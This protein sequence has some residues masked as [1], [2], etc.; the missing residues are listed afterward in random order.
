MLLSLLLVAASN[1]DAACAAGR[2]IRWGIMGSGLIS[3]DFVGALKALPADEAKVIAVGARSLEAAQAFATSLGVPKAH[4]GYEALANDPDVDVVYVGT[5]AQ[6]HAD[7][8]RIA[9]AA[10]KPV[11]V[12]KPLAMNGEEAAELVALAKSRG[13]FLLE[14]MWTRFFPAVV[15]AR[16]LLEAG[17]IGEVV[18]VSADFGWPADP[19]GEH[20]RTVDPVSGGVGMDVA[21]YPVAHVLLAAG[22]TPP[23]SVVATG[24]TRP[25]AGGGRVDWSVAAGLSGFGD[26]PALSATVLCTLDASTP[27]EV[28]Y[29]GKK[30]TLRLH[31]PAHTPSRLTLSIAEGREAST[32]ETLEFALPPVPAGALPFNYPGSQGFVYEAAAVNRALREGRLEAEEW[33]HAESVTTQRIVDQLR[34]SVVRAGGGKREARGRWWDLRTW[35]WRA[36]REG[37]TE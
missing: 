30:G 14:G 15:K 21:M 11:L 10:G 17:A 26:R 36:R 13:L 4:A 29:T 25:A 2:P 35:G 37:A 23:A 34:S 24:S 1:D 16:E 5:V 22:A 20:G 27:E 8:A 9:L 12:E 31:R 18:A 6:T 33:T 3:S 32:D 28:V 7:C 19:D